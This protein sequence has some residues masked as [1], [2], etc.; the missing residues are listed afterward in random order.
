MTSVLLL[1]LYIMLMNSWF[2]ILPVILIDDSSYVFGILLASISNIQTKAKDSAKSMNPIFAATPKNFRIG[3][4][5]L[6]R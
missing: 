3:G 4:D 5:V 2:L 1:I 6:V